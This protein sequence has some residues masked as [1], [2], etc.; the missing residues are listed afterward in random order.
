[1]TQHFARNIYTFKTFWQDIKFMISH[2]KLIRQ[3]M[4]DLDQAFVE[5]IMTVV[6]AVNGCRY[7]SWFHARQAVSSGISQEEVQQMMKLQF[8]A[9]ASEEELM[10]LLYA[11]HYAETRRKPS[12]EMTEKLVAAYGAE[13]A[14]EIEMV[15]RMITFGNLS[16][17]TFDAFLSRLKGIKAEGSSA[18]FEFVFFIFGA[19]F[20][21]P[22]LPKLR[23]A[24]S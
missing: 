15:I 23:T 6:T 17:N 14:K 10:A 4:R 19:P 11:Q 22:L 9:D 21:L 24:E 7:C 1:M 13:K 8:Q 20:L 12:P 3:T 2:G 18:F 5:K 16:G